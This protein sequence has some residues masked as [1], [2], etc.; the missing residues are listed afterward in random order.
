[1]PF[2]DIALRASR[3]KPVAGD[4][5]RAIHEGDP[6]WPY[7]GSDGACK[8]SSRQPQTTTHPIHTLLTNS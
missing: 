8:I 3:P 6:T 2:H 1:M 5:A 7:G 4:P